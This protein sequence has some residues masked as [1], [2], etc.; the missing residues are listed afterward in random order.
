[1]FAVKLLVANVCASFGVVTVAS[2]GTC[3]ET[4]PSPICKI[5]ILLVPAVG[6]AAK[7]SVTPLSV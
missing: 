4:C 1:V 3:V 7:L 5:C 2:E 6:A